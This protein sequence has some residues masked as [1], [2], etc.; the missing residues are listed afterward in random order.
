MEPDF[1][2]FFEDYANANVP[3]VELTDVPEGYTLAEYRQMRKRRPQPPPMELRD[4]LTGK[5]VGY[6]YLP[7]TEPDPLQEIRDF[8]EWIDVHLQSVEE[9]LRIYKEKRCRGS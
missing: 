2:R 9:R 1:N 5:L 8:I 6:K 4:G 3:T 7:G